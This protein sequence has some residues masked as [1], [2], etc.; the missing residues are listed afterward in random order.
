MNTNNNNNKC[1]TNCSKKRN[2]KSLRQNKSDTY[3]FSGSSRT[4]RNLG[5]NNNNN[6]IFYNSRTSG[7]W[8]K[9]S[10]GRNSNSRDNGSDGAD[11]FEESYSVRIS[12]PFP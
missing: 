7:F 10:F 8:S 12:S 5:I 4:S 1:L 3:R 2:K 11:V 6:N 9:L